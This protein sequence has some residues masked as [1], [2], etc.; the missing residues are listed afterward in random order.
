[1]L[2]VDSWSSYMNIFKLWKW[3]D[4]QQSSGAIIVLDA[5]VQQLSTH[6]V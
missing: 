4:C 3:A 2:F 5:A 6:P 1:M